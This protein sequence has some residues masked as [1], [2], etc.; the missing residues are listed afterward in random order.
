MFLHGNKAETALKLVTD[1]AIA[2]FPTA[3]GIASGTLRFTYRFK[4]PFRQWTH[5]I[6]FYMPSH[7]HTSYQ[8]YRASKRD[9]I[10]QHQEIY[11]TGHF[12]T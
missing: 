4:I 3:S 6:C 9:G 8:R 2:A 12:A 1:E 11:T 10:E 5:R 7:A